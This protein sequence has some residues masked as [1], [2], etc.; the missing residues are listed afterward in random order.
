M[1]G[2]DLD[3]KLELLIGAA[4]EEVST[5]EPRPVPM[6]D[7]GGCVYRAARGGSHVSLLKVLLSNVCENDCAYCANRA[8]AHIRR[9]TLGPEELAR[10]FDSMRRSGLVEGLFLSSGLCGNPV[11]TMDRLLDTVDIVRRKYGFTGYVHLKILPGASSDQIEHAG[12]IADRISVNLEAPSPK[13][14]ALIAPEKKFADLLGILNRIHTLAAT[15]GHFAPAGPTTQFVA[16]AAGESD[17]ELLSSANVLYSRF[18][19]SRVYYSGFRP[20]PGTPLEDVPPMPHRR[21]ARLYQADA[22]LRDYGFR[23]EDLPFDE[24]GSLPQGQDPKLAWA[25][26]HPECFPVEVNTAGR[27][28]LLQVPGIGPTGADRIL[29]LRRQ[30]RLRDLGQLAKAGVATSRCASFITL[31]GKRPERQISLPIP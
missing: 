27:K 29:R 20:V 25:L 5:A 10:A 6:P 2:N 17:S 9:G 3:A 19:L 11:R 14:L 23:A 4:C 21:E 13:R 7:L 12:L 28:A 31:N 1:K 15:Y 22:L 16:G 30:V 24:T 26:R 8:S 18:G